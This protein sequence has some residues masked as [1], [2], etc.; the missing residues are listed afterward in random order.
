MLQVS[1]MVQR[2]CITGHWQFCT[3]SKACTALH[4][5]RCKAASS[6]CNRAL[7][8]NTRFEQECLEWR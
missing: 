8:L 5:V 6:T 3:A 7:N 4:D 2:E 1:S